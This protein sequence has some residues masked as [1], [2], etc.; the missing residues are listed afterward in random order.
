MTQREWF[1]KIT[2]G[3]VTFWCSLHFSV[4]MSYGYGVRDICTY[5]I[6]AG[7]HRIVLQISKWIRDFPLEAQPSLYALNHVCFLDLA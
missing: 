6:Y 3:S 4:Q 5:R 1:L 7:I 2:D